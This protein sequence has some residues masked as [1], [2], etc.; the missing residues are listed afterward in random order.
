MFTRISPN[1]VHSSDGFKVAVVRRLELHY[2]DRHGVFVI[3][4]EPMEDGELVVSVTSIPGD[5]IEEVRN[6]VSAALDFLGIRY[7]FD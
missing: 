6:R 4:V 3:P 7:R 1:A 2:E 5:R